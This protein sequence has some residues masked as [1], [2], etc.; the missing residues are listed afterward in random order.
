MAL[1]PLG[2]A[3]IRESIEWHVDD[4][5]CGQISQGDLRLL[6][7]LVPLG[8]DINRLSAGCDGGALRVAVDAQNADAVAW[9]LAHGAD[10]DHGDKFG[11][12]PLGRAARNG[13]VELVKLLLDADAGFTQF[14]EYGTPVIDAARQCH[15]DVVRVLVARGA[16]PPTWFDANVDCLPR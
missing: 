15:A 12:T 2:W 11:T 3:P 1:A 5:V 4:F 10:P 14:G 7:A 9:L 8:F 6:K 16:I 13:N